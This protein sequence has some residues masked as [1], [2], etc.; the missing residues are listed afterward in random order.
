MH[1]DPYNFVL[2]F[3][4]DK[5]HVIFHNFKYRYNTGRDLGLLIYSLNRA[6]N[7]YKC[8]KNLFLEG[9]S[10]DDKNIREALT[11]FSGSLRAY[12]RGKENFK[13]VYYL[14]SSPE[15]GSACKRMNMFLRWMARPAP[16]D[17]GIWSEISTEKLIIPLD[18]H[19]AKLSRKLHLTSRA[20]DDWKTAE[21]ITERLKEFDPNDP[22]KYDFAIFG[23]GITG[24]LPACVL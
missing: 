23:M 13:G 20:S 22:V 1:N 2:N 7:E 6:I 14:L 15:Q 9:Y 11:H 8:L 3:N 18:T 21:E 24:D 12:L 10:D 4:Y 19:V 16:V 5:D 17:L